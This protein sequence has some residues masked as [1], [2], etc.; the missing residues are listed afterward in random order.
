MRPDRNSFSARL[1]VR[2]CPFKIKAY[3][4]YLNHGMGAQLFY[5][6]KTVC[7]CYGEYESGQFGNLQ[8]HKMQ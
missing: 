6:T 2:P 5:L 1:V 4:K 8:E 7:F 3:V